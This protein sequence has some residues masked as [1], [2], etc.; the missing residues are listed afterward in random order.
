MARKIT[1]REKIN[2]VAGECYPYNLQH[3]NNLYILGE[4]RERYTMQLPERSKDIP[5]DS[6][7]NYV[8]DGFW[9]GFG[10]F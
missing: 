7:L 6:V 3:L 1:V 5:L 4:L 10:T 2:Q 8:D 9:D